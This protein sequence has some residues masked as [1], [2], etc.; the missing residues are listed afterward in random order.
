MAV[1]EMLLTITGADRVAFQIPEDTRISTDPE[2][3]IDPPE[4]VRRIFVSTR[5]SDDQFAK[6]RGDPEISAEPVE[7]I[8]TPVYVTEVV[9]FPLPDDP[10]PVITFTFRLAVLLFPATSVAEYEI[11]YVPSV[12]VSGVPVLVTVQL[13]STLSVHVVP[14]STNPLH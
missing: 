4:A 5:F 3:L 1:L 9:T 8:M 10:E 14:G 7:V 6:L 12:F 2:R 13:T 11:T